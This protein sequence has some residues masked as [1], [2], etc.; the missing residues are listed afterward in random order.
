M[1]RILRILLIALFLY[2]VWYVGS[3]AWDISG[4][5]RDRDKDYEFVDDYDDEI[6]QPPDTAADNLADPNYI[7]D[8]DR[9]NILLIGVDSPAP[10]SRRSPLSDTIILFSLHKT[11]GQAVLLS[12]PRD[13][14]VY[15]PGR[16][17]DKINHSHAFGGAALLRQAVGGFTDLPID[18]Y[19]RVDFEGFKA[20]VDKLGGVDMYVDRD[21]PELGL[22]KGQQILDGNKALAYVRDRNTAG[23][24]GRIDRQQRFL[25]AIMK[26]VQAQP[27]TQFSPVIREGAKHIDT[28]MPILTLLDFAREFWNYNPDKALRYVIPGSPFYHN[29]IYYLRPDIDAAR[30]FINENLKV[31]RQ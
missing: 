16:G 11:D 29:E 28:D 2:G 5:F 6:P 17:N 31:P 12:I 15:I 4:I 7:A 9:L 10:G 1:K 8:P 14:Y 20:I 30:E 18:Y 22:Y 24:Y 25:V 21:I 26:Q 3:F 19:M 23:D 13:T 27:F